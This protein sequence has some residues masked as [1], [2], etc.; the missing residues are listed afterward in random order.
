MEVV[1]LL[2]PID[3]AQLRIQWPPSDVV[4]ESLVAVDHSKEGVVD[5]NWA[6]DCPPGLVPRCGEAI[7]LI[8]SLA[9]PGI[10]PRCGIDFT[11]GVWLL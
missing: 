1:Q 10:M 3:A 5:A 4:D 9:P 11:S 7:S 6:A 2:L 8:A